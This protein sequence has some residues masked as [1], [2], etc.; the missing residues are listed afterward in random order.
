MSTMNPIS[1]NSLKPIVVISSEN[2]F[3]QGM[4]QTEPILED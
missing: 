4:M 2:N 1:Q 3:N